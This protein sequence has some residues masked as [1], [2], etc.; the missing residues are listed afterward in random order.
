MHKTHANS[1]TLFYTIYAIQEVALLTAYSEQEEGSRPLHMPSALSPLFMHNQY[2]PAPR[3]AGSMLASRGG[4]SLGLSAGSGGSGGS[5]GGEHLS[6]GTEAA[7][8]E[9]AAEGPASKKCRTEAG[10]QQ[11]QQE[12]QQQQGKEAQGDVHGAAAPLQAGRAAAGSKTGEGARG[13]HGKAAGAASTLPVLQLASS[14][15]G[16]GGGG[17]LNSTGQS[18]LSDPGALSLP[19]GKLRS[20]MYPPDLRHS[21]ALAATLSCACLPHSVV[22]SES[23]VLC[24]AP[25]RRLAVLMTPFL[26]G[27]NAA[28]MCSLAD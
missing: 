9:F 25:S 1:H 6:R 19:H 28:C 5:G 7:A 3:S 22:V 4:P 23:V 11:Q 20:A 17:A 16:G 27:P 15:A 24:D 21:G 14:T 18:P 10:L 13:S 26:P 8:A 2:P 12:L